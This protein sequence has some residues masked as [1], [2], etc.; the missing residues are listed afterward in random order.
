MVAYKSDDIVKQAQNIFH[1]AQLIQLIQVII[2]IIDIDIFI[3]P[4]MVQD[5]SAY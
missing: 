4:Y 5:K 1:P 2:L 3:H